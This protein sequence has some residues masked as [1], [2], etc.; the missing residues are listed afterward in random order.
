VSPLSQLHSAPSEPAGASKSRLGRT[1]KAHRPAAAGAGGPRRAGRSIFAFGLCGAARPLAEANAALQRGDYET[2]YALARPLADRGLAVAQLVLGVM[3]GGGHGVPQNDAEAA[4][5]LQRA[6]DQGCAEAQ[7]I[8]GVMYAKGQGVT[9]NDAK[10]AKWFRRAADQDQAA[11]Q[12]NLGLLYAQGRGVARND[13]EAAKWFHKAADQG[14]VEAQT[15]LGLMYVKGQG[16]T[17]N[18]LLAHMWLNLAAA[19]GEA[20]ALADRDC[21]ARMMTPAQIAEAQR[22]AQERTIARGYR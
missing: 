7:T 5:W 19:Q 12:S 18:Y 4:S 2:A 9:Q 17:Q 20:G 3:H 1:I 11:A 6:A 16:V 10:A 14:L 8:L 13:A 21:L 22:L 15:I